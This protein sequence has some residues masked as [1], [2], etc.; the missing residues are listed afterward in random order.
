MTKKHDPFYDDTLNIVCP[1][2]N[3][4]VLDDCHIVIEFGYGS[5]KDMTTY[6][7]SP[8]H[9][10]VG[11]KVLKFID[12]L[13]QKEYKDHPRLGVKIGTKPSVEDFGSCVM[14]ELFEEENGE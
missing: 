5:D 11:E 13:I 9:D 12:D 14:N 6:T 4:D 2:T 8:V 3:K 7:F 10:E 1:I